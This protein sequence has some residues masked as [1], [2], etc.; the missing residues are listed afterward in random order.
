MLRISKLFAAALLGVMFIIAAPCLYAERY[1][2][3]INRT[4]PFHG[5]RV[6]IDHSFGAVSVR[7]GSE[8]DVRVH[9]VIRASDSDLGKEIRVTVTASPTGGVAIKTEYPAM[10]FHGIHMSNSYSV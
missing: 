4:L 6:S 7:A 3:T 1:E 5:G 8:T 2:Q 9:A 10:H